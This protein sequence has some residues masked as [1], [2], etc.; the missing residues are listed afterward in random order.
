MLHSKNGIPCEH[1]LLKYS[2]TIFFNKQNLTNSIENVIAIFFNLSQSEHHIKP[3]SFD[4]KVK[5]KIRN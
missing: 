5:I 1:Y 4:L 2:S 3:S